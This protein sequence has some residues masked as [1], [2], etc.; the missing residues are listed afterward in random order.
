MRAASVKYVARG[1][2]LWVTGVFRM[3]AILDTSLSGLDRASAL[4]LDVFRYFLLLSCQRRPEFHLSNWA[5]L[6]AVV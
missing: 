4:M 6:C 5:W 3:D 2:C 1:F